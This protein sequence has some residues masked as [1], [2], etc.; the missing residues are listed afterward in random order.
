[1]AYSL[2]R[3]TTQACNYSVPVAQLVLNEAAIGMLM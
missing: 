1:M 2:T 3:I